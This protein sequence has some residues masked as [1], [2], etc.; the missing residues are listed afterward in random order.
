MPPF[1]AVGESFLLMCASLIRLNVLVA[2]TRRIRMVDLLAI[3]DVELLNALQDTSWGMKS[4]HNLEWLLSVHCELRSR[5]RSHGGPCGKRRCRNHH[6]QIEALKRSP[7][8]LPHSSSF[9]QTYKPALV[10][11]CGV[12]AVA[13]LFASHKSIS[14]QNAPMQPCWPCRSLT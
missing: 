9:M 1:S 3:L 14:A 12:N 6:D 5:A 13:T 10:A 2:E 8:W 7:S 11:G 4:G